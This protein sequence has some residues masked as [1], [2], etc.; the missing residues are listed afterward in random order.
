M[1]PSAVVADPDYQRLKS[2]LI[3]S[4]GLAYYRE[5]DEELARHIA[6]RLEAFGVDGCGAYLDVL[7]DRQ[8]GESELDALLAQL[9]IGETYFFRHSE[10]FDALRQIVIPNILERNETSRRLHIWSAGCATGAEPYSLAVLLREFDAQTANWN[11]N[12]LGTDVNRRFLTEANEGRFE[13]WAFRGVS[14]EFK[15]R[16][17]RRAGKFWH[18]APELRKRVTFQYHNLVKHT[19]PSLMNNLFGFD[20]IVCRNVMIYFDQL[21]TRTVLGRFQDSLVEGGWLVVGHAESNLELFRDFRAVSAPGTTLYQKAAQAQPPSPAADSVFL[22]TTF[23]PD[24]GPSLARAGAHAAPA[25]LSCQP[26]REETPSQAAPSSDEKPTL[27]NLRTLAG[28]GNWDAAASECRRL[29][30]GNGLDPLTHFYSALILEQ[31]GTVAEAEEE[32]RRAIY[33]DRKFVLAHYHL[34]LLQQRKRK[35]PLARRS[36]ENVLELLSQRADTE[37]F[38]DADGITVAELRELVKVHLEVLRS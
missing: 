34:G 3:E 26:P 27:E 1:I 22:P 36:F 38:A 2:H 33:V 28:R 30:D 20:L 4:T 32:L 31:M 29:L 11:V 9:T 25:P 7:R 5:R 10:Q 13:D 35:E 24:S 37:S 18:I 8:K 6:P 21:V 14:A 15:E 19:F 23:S 17:F 12:I 16:Y